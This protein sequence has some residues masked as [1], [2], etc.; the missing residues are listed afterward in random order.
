MCLRAVETVWC[1]VEAM[2]LERWAVQ[3]RDSSRVYRNFV[4]I[5]RAI[6]RV[7]GSR[8]AASIPSVSANELS[9]FTA[10]THSGSKDSAESVTTINRNKVLMEQQMGFN[11]VSYCKRWLSE[12]TTGAFH[13]PIMQAG[14]SSSCVKLTT[15]Q[16]QKFFLLFSF[17]HLLLWLLD[18]QRPAESWSFHHWNHDAFKLKPCSRWA[19]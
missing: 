13:G 1:G 7:E 10:C 2:W 8:W 11:P 4:L 15:V 3:Q 17:T 16:T 14:S 12:N 19:Q 5:C 6:K 9:R 18:P